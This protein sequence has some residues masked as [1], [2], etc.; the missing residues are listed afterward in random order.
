MKRRIIDGATL[1][2]ASFATACDIASVVTFDPAGAAGVAAVAAGG[3]LC[4]R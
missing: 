4:S 1:A 2:A 3:A